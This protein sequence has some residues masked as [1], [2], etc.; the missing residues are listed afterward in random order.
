MY[1]F[2]FKFKCVVEIRWCVY[3]LIVSSVLTIFSELSFLADSVS[4]LFI[5]ATLYTI[6]SRTTDTAISQNFYSFLNESN[7]DE[8]HLVFTVFSYSLVYKQ[9]VCKVKQLSSLH[10]LNSHN[11]EKKGEEKT[12][13]LIVL[14]LMGD[15][16]IRSYIYL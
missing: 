7:I 5:G 13:S 16:E 14:I 2:L 3:D 9:C 10:S 12:D 15:P 8:I 6:T 4:Y 11:D 1:V